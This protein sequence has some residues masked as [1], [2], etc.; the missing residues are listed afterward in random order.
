MEWRNVEKGG[1]MIN[2]GRSDNFLDESSAKKQMMI[3]I[4]HQLLERD[5][6]WR[7]LRARA[8]FACVRSNRTMVTKKSITAPM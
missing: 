4:C 3:C 8:R 6:R 5:V 1:G 7:F 2:P